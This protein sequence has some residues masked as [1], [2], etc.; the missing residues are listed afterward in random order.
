MLPS[1]PYLGPRRYP[2]DVTFP[3]LTEREQEVAHYLTRGYS[4]K[5]IAAELG[6]SQRTIEAHRARVFQKLRVR[7]AVELT[8]YYWQLG[9][10]RSAFP[11][12]NDLQRLNRTQRAALLAR[13][14]DQYRP[15]ASGETR[16]AA[17]EDPS[18]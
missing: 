2:A 17:S 8:D 7:N 13:R 9:H 4:N 5:L 11:R 6:R 12:F 15:D 14:W 3:G 1:K 10:R 16:A 18:S